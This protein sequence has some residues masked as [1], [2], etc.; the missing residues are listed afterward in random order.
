MLELTFNEIFVSLVTMT[1][2]T[3]CVPICDFD[4]SLSELSILAGKLPRG[5]KITG[6][7]RVHKVF[8]EIILSMFY[9]VLL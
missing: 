8:T 3:S 1:L 5:E 2:G 6:L 9:E 7:K 4:F